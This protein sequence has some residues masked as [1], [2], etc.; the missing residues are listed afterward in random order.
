VLLVRTLLPVLAC[1]AL[2]GADEHPAASPASPNEIA[3]F[4]AGL[5]SRDGGV[6]KSLEESEDW[7]AHA[8]AF[9]GAWA[10]VQQDRLPRM[11]AF[12]AKE[13]R[14]E[15]VAGATVFYPFGGPDALTVLTLFPGHTQYV[16]VGL[17]PAGTIPQIQRMTRKDLGDELAALRSSLDSVMIRSFFITRQM[18]RTFR[19]QVTDGLLPALMVLVARMNQT[20][21]GVRWIR[22]E[23]DGKVVERRPEEKV[24]G[25]SGVEIR[26]RTG[27][28]PTE[29]TLR[30]FS[31]NLGNE[32]LAENAGFQAFV[33][34]SGKMVTYFKATSYMTHRKEFS[35]IRELVLNNSRAVLQDDSGIPFKFFDPGTWQVQLYG[36][37]TQ[38]YGSFRYLIQKDL[39]QAY[40]TPG[41]AKPLDFKIGYG[42]SRIPSN[43]LL[44]RRKS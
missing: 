35:V 26:F 44:A 23:D 15:A 32:K 25:R 22:I 28:D 33:R 31:V 16:L 39:Q 5:A 40:R 30:Y 7:K 34:S 24:A 41:T 2:F 8:V 19:G 20:I 3:R 29:R 1:V 42:Y 38:P 36:D 12:Y 9:Q 27:G 43:L 14:S 4:L 21:T 6:L 18:D 37:Y 11:G 13:L 17:E 10:K